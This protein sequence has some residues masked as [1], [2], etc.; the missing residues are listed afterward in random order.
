MAYM[1]PVDTTLHL[2][3]GISM[4][5]KRRLL[6]FLLAILVAVGAADGV[7]SIG[8]Y[9][10]RFYLRH[11]IWRNASS[12][13]IY[14]NGTRLVRSLG[15]QPQSI[16]NSVETPIHFDLEMNFGRFGQNR[17]RRDPGGPRV[18][19]LGIRRQVVDR[20][21]LAAMAVAALSGHRSGVGGIASG[22]PAEG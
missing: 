11:P 6:A 10:W 8:K 9:A 15:Y 3:T 16:C 13:V 19:A 4:G 2:F 17:L 1:V 20:L 7:R 12:E 5:R 22:C 21:R 14:G 18:P